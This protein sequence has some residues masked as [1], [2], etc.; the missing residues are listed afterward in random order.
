MPDAD[1]KYFELNNMLDMEV[2]A[3]FV[4]RAIS[5]VE[6]RVK[7][8][9][10]IFDGMMERLPTNTISTFLTRDITSFSKEVWL[11]HAPRF[12]CSSVYALPAFRSSHL[13]RC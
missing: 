9:T 4:F 13:D 7:P 3:R 6:W 2:S 8:D 10:E 11:R 5:K 12:A 1:A